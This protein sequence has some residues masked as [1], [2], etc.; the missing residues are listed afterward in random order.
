MADMVWKELAE[1]YYREI[2]ALQHDILLAHEVFEKK[3]PKSFAQGINIL[4]KTVEIS[5]ENI[6]LLKMRE[7]IGK[8]DKVNIVGK[9]DK[10]ENSLFKEY[11][12]V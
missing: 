1:E 8:V 11:F 2:M 3:V 7:P 5:E 4:E 10:V 12:D 6:R 9:V